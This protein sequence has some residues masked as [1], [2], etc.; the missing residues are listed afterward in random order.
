MVVAS[1]SQE[2]EEQYEIYDHYVPSGWKS[3]RPG[4]D[5]TCF[6]SPSDQDEHPERLT[7]CWRRFLRD[8]DKPMILT[9]ARP[10]ERKNSECWSGFT[11]K[12]RNFNELAN[13]VVVMGTREDLRDFPK[14]N[15]RC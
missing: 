4:V 1:T 10:D 7:S 11:A 13:L 14:P 6:P 5:L 9:M 12:V 8:P 15:G 2:V 3:F